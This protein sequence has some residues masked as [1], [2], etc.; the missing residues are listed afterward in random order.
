MYRNFV[1][2]LRVGK[3][4]LMSDEGHAAG[5]N[6]AA[7]KAGE[8]GMLK[9][10]AIAGLAVSAVAFGT[11][12]ATSNVAPRDDLKSMRGAELIEYAAKPY[13]Q[14][15]EDIDHISASMPDS[16]EAMRDAYFRLASHDN[17]TMA[18]SWI[19]YAAMIAAESP[20]FHSAIEAQM[21]K[22]GGAK[23][24]AAQIDADPASVRSLPG[25]EAAIA[26]IM[27]FATN[28]AAR[29]RGL[30][31]TF[32]AEAYEMQ[33]VQWARR[34]IAMDG[35]AR[36]DAALQYAASR[37]WKAAPHQASS[38]R[39][40]AVRPTLVSNASWSADW[41]GTNEPVNPSARP[42]TIVGKAL[43]L[44]ARYVLNDA[45]Q[46]DLAAYGTSRRSERCFN[47]AQMNL[48]QCI[49][50]TRTPY[51][52]A[53]CLG[54]HALNDMSSCVGWPAGADAAGS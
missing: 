22:R 16:E 3:P 53:F 21:K 43:V 15:R 41:S 46:T 10:F 51:E 36:V 54:Q 27:E 44:G 35:M 42:G 4:T 49:A 14:F 13:I 52:E 40:G 6:P 20:E 18:A 37:E 26:A 24:L 39:S 17:R 11:A 2:V 7:S 47:N 38:G 48:D 33:K 23:A 45:E 50:A 31:D 19:A 5:R 25:A 29:I 28:D 9:S 1:N 34:A 8:L 30:G 12:G 32:I